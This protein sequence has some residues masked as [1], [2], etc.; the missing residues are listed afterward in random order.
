MFVD[1]TK[2]IESTNVV[3]HEYM[4]V[5]HHKS[6]IWKVECPECGGFATQELPHSKLTG[7]NAPAGAALDLFLVAH[8]HMEYAAAD[9]ADAQQAYLDG[10]HSQNISEIGL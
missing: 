3:S 6:K 2:V 8:E 10:F 1:V 4:N 9:G 5:D 7:L